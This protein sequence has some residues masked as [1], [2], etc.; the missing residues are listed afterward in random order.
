MTSTSRFK[1]VCFDWG[2]TI[3]IGKPTI[4]ETVLNVWGKFAL[5]V[6][7]EE[8]FKAAQLS[9]VELTKMLP[10]RKDLQDMTEFRQMLYARQAELMS[11]A[12]GIDPDLPD[13]PWVANTFFN[14]F[15]FKNRS[16]QI[17]G[18]HIQLLHQLRQHKIQLAVISNDDDPAEQPKLISELGLI[19]YFAFEISSSAYGYEKPHPKIFLAT[20]SKLDLRADEVIFI[21]DD[22]HNDYWGAEQVGMYSLLFDPARLYVNVKNIRRIERLEEV[23]GYLFPA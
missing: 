8:I 5:T 7:A 14:E 18:S 19:G 21:G 17:P 11:D 10:L 15:Y 13:W 12:L 16:W 6:S 3:E 22:F 1:A 2:N 4:K 20:L 23:F 9:R